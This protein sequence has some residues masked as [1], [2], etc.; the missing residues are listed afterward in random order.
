VWR[1][2]AQVLGA[3]ADA[4]GFEPLPSAGSHVSS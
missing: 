1:V 2:V 3:A 4:A